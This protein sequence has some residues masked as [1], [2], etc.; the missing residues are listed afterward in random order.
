MR[1]TKEL[2]TNK[3]ITLIALVITIIVMLILVAV[4]ITM[5]I[6]G[7]LFGH[8]RTAGRKTNNAVADEQALGTGRIKIGDYWYDSPEDY[9]KGIKSADQGDDEVTDGG[10]TGGGTG[11]PAAGREPSPALP[12]QVGAGFGGGSGPVFRHCI[13]AGSAGPDGKPLPEPA[14]LHWQHLL[15][16]QQPDRR[17][18]QPGG[19]DS[20]GPSRNGICAAAD[21]LP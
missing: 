18:H 21:Q 8:A 4:T 12:P 3:G 7:G 13:P 19:G 17:Y 9:V 14:E 1:K 6:N 16:R 15:Q 5:A 11:G 20:E 2:K 10:T